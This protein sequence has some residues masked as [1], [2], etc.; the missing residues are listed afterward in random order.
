MIFWLVGMVVLAIQYYYVEMD[1]NHRRIQGIQNLNKI[2]N[3]H[4]T[5]SYDVKV[6]VG[7]RNYFNDEINMSFITLH[8]T[9]MLVEL[10]FL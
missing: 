10:C 1:D 4:G 2:K 6:N 7:Y 3:I 9:R 8:E 5:E